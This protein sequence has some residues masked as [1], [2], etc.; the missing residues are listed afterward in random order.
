MKK[1]GNKQERKFQEKKKPEDIDNE[2]N[3]FVFLPSTI[4]QGTVAEW[5]GSGLQNQLQR[6]ESAR[7]LKKA[8]DNIDCQGLCFLAGRKTG[9]VGLINCSFYKTIYLFKGKKQCESADCISNEI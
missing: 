1:N 8:P 9:I 5:L 7:Y 6:F 2:Y 4:I 3:F